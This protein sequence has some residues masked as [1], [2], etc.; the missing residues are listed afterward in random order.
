[1]ID[2]YYQKI[3][4]PSNMII[5]AAGNLR[6]RHLVALVE[7]RFAALLPNG[8]VPADRPPTTHAR[9]TLR[10]KKSLEQVHVCLGV[11]CYPLPHEKRYVTYVLNTLLG[12]SMSSRL[13]QN[14]REKQGLAYSVFSELSAFRDTG[15]LAVYAGTSREAARRVLALILDEFRRLKQ[16]RLGEEE[17]RRV[18]DSLKGSLMLGLESTASRMANLARQALYFGRFFSMDELVESIEKVSRDEV[19]QIAQAFFDPKHIALT[20]LGN[21]DGF[22]VGR[23]D[24]VC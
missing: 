13:F 15:C 6:H 22:R 5:T 24:L 17:L 18:K 10:N 2:R 19:Q 4:V 14:I 8:V 21:L 3:Y 12:G 23:E 1:M 11:P 7:E 16:E 20:V 9:L